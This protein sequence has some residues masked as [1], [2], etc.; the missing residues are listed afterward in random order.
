LAS[1]YFDEKECL[2]PQGFA[3]F[4]T[5]LHRA[6]AIDETMRCYNDALDFVLEAREKEERRKWVD[7]L[8]KSAFA[9]LLNTTL[10][11]YQEEGIRFSAI[12]GRAIIADEMGLGKTIQA[13]GTAMLL[14]GKGLVSSVLVLCPTSL[15][16]QWKREIEHF[17]NEKAHV[18][19]GTHLKRREQYD[20]PKLFKIVS[21]NSA[22]NDVKV[23]GS[24]ETDMVIIDEVQRLKNWNTQIARAARKIN[25]HYAIILSGTPLENRLEELVS[26][27]ELVDQFC[28][29]P[30]YLFRDRYIIT[31]DKGATIGYKNLNEIK[32]KLKGVLIRR[33]KRQVRLQMPARQD[34]NLLV[35]MTEEQM[36]IH[37]EAK[38]SHSA[39]T[40][41][42][43]CP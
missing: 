27:I 7:S 40:G 19:E 12:A 24:L 41:R 38:K 20:A 11:P 3:H 8:G 1:E 21:Y 23:L 17:T 30:Y 29:A 13:I 34:K 31:D 33:T 22:C 43:C 9:H 39:E 4:E 14:H 15:K 5:F 42:D 36:T 10:Y 28:L 25:S 16:Y 35:P 37:N 26:I 18:I 6:K 32:E 2:L